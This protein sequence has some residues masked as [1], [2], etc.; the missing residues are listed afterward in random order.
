VHC[1]ASSMLAAYEL[2]LAM[3]QSSTEL[4]LWCCFQRPAFHTG[5]RMLLLSTC[6]DLAARFAGVLL[7]AATNRPAGLDPALLRPGRL[8][9]LLYVPPPDT[10]GRE[11][12]LRLHTRWAHRC[13]STSHACC[14]MPPMEC[15][16]R[17]GAALSI[18]CMLHQR[19][20]FSCCI[21]MLRCAL[22]VC[23]CGVQG[24]AAG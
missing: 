20:G 23:V 4:C 8:D 15:M 22:L 7:L 18:E 11:A 2:L 5:R 19:M 12:I 17:R 14:D 10:A 21:L 6:C 3:H 13:I 1:L 9:V 24:H 16:L